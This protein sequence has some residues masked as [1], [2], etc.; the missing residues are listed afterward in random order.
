MD[1]R[2]LAN[3]AIVGKH[4]HRADREV[5][6]LAITATETMLEL[7]GS[8]AGPGAAPRL[9]R[10]YAVVGVHGIEPPPALVLSERLPGVSRPAQLLVYHFAPG[11]AGPDDLGDGEDER[12]VAVEMGPKPFLGV[13]AA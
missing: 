7:V 12:A 8:I 2:P 4:R 6:I 13:V 11:I 10:G 5:P 3:G 1:P 9:V